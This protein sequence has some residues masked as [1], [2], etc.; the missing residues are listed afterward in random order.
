M[1]LKCAF[2]NITV[3]TTLVGIDLIVSKLNSAINS[4]NALS[5]LTYNFP[6]AERKKTLDGENFSGGYK[7]QI[8][9]KSKEWFN[10]LPDDT[11]PAFSFFYTNSPKTNFSD[12]KINWTQTINLVVWAN[13]NL[14]DPNEDSIFKENLIQQVQQI[15]IDNKFYDTI[16]GVVNIYDDFDSTWSDF[17]IINDDYA[18]FIK[19]NTTTFRIEFDVRGTTD[20]CLC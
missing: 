11:V 10:L 13:L 14:I 4:C 1:D 16:E 17:D 18:R 20:S 8:Y 12:D 7:P 2:E 5:F 6:K 3:P 19:G 9:L 15:I